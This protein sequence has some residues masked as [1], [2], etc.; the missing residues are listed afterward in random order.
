MHITSPTYLLPIHIAPG[1]RYF[2]TT[3]NKSFLFIG[4][5]NAIKWQGLAALYRRRDVAGVEAYL[6]DLAA[7][8]V[9]ILRLMLEYA[10]TDG[11]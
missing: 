2:E 11:D 1:G 4:T 10:H 3:D 8:R 7:H 5:N 6:T 9:T